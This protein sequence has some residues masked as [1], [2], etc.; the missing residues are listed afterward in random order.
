MQE[1]RLILLHDYHNGV[2]FLPGGILNPQSDFIGRHTR[3]H[4][5]IQN[6]FTYDHLFPNRERCGRGYFNDAIGLW[7]VLSNNKLL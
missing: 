2:R 4:A 5:H 7:N 6:D 3:G 1:R